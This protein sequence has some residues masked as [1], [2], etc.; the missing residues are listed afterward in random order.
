M[1]DTGVGVGLVDGR[2]FDDHDLGQR[3]QELAVGAIEQR[4]FDQSLAAELLFI[5]RDAGRP[6]GNRKNIG[7][8]RCVLSVE[9]SIAV[10]SASSIC[11]ALPLTVVP[12]RNTPPTSLRC[13]IVSP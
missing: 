13:L 8:R 2:A 3:R 12:T 10:K 4:R 6:I 5:R 7:R 1:L 9:S 11:L